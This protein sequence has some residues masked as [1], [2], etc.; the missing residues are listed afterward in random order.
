MKMIQ[1]PQRFLL[2]AAMSIA[3]PGAFAIGSAITDISA[4]PDGG[5]V[6]VDIGLT[7][8]VKP[9]VHM[10]GEM[11]LL[12]L[13]FPNVDLQTQSRRIMVNHAG[14][15][16]IHA[17]IHSAVPMD[18]W[19]VVGIDSARPIGMETLGNH[20]VL[21][22]LPH[23]TQANTVSQT[24]ASTSSENRLTNSASL[25][26]SVPTWRLLAGRSSS[27]LPQVEPV[28]VTAEIDEQVDDCPATARNRFKIK[29]VSGRTAYIDGGTRAGLRMGMNL[30]IHDTAGSPDEGANSQAPIGAARIVFVATTSAVMEVGTSN[31]E[32]K[33]GDWS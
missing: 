3:A 1:T 14:V 4:A 12:V 23:P 18:T 21:R 6:R 20:L 25:A 30:D 16:A 27:A 32:L 5:T 33:V 22:I 26:N 9:I 15:G 31:R 13:D 19:I 2:L 29:F 7:S 24:P 10:A 17:A 11:G 8:P 28:P